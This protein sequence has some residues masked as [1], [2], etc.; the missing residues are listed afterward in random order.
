MNYNIPQIIVQIGE[1]MGEI[2]LDSGA[3]TSYFRKSLV[4][5]HE[6]TG[7]VAQDF[8]AD[9][10]T[11]ESEIYKI[12][13]LLDGEV[14]NIESGF[15]PHELEKKLLF[16]G[17]GVVGRSLFETCEKVAFDFEEKFFLMKKK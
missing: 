1:E 2:F 3:P 8:Y 13:I 15:L 17:F 4:V 16:L 5:V 12:P 7:E 10:G 14:F 9:F 11:F 6:K